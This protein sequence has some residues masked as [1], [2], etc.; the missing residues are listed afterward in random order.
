MFFIF[1]QVLET[2]ALFST[3]CFVMD[4]NE[5]DSGPQNIS[6]CCVSEVCLLRRVQ[7]W[8]EKT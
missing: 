1:F 4:M 7:F 2:I 5:L 6:S 8:R 3:Q